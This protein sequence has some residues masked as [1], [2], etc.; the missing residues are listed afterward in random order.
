M[1]VNNRRRET[2]ADEADHIVRLYDGNL[3]FVDQEL[4]FLRRSLEAL[5]LWE[6]TLVIVTADHGEEMGEHGLFGHEAQLFEPALRIPLVIR[7]PQAAGLAGRR[8]RGL[9]DLVDLAPTIADVYGLL[10]RGGSAESFGGR[11]LLPMLFGAPGKPRDRVA[12]ARRAAALGA[13][14]RPLQARLRRQAGDPPALR[15]AARPRGA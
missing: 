10:G 11:T 14:R 1:A 5:G 8:V 12:H 2:T 3:A 15:S 13:A 9:V 6:R 4:G 7:F